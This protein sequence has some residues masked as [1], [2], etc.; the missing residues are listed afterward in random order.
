M[1]D[2][3]AVVVSD[4]HN[5][6]R[7]GHAAAGPGTAVGVAATKD[8]VMVVVKVKS[9]ETESVVALADV[10]E[11]V[12]IDSGGA[13]GL[14]AAAGRVLAEPLEGDGRERAEVDIAATSG[15]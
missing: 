6:R 1:N 4:V 14:D 10:V 11:M 13:S 9:V 7:D 5:P 12:T 15:G 3:L 2:L 8:A